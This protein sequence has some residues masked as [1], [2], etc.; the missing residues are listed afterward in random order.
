MEMTAPY[1]GIDVAKASLEVFGVPGPASLPN[2]PKAA[3]ALART[4]LKQK[5]TLIALEAT[6]GYERLV[7]HTLLEAGLP[8]VRLN[9]LRVRRFAQSIG[10]LAKTDAI[11]AKL[12]A[13]YA[14]V[15]ADSLSPMKATSET[16]KMLKELIARRRQLVQQCTASRAQL[17]HVTISSVKA[18]IDRTIKHLKKEI[19]AIETLI[20]KQIDADE[21]MKAKAAIL[22]S[23]PGIDPRVAAILIS[24]L[25]ELGEI[26]RRQIA[27]LVGVAPF[28][29]DS[30]THKG[31]RHIQGGRP[32]VR[33]ALYMATLVG[34]RRDG[35]LKA[36][37]DHLVNAGKPKKVAIVACMRTRL[38]YLTALVK[39]NKHHQPNA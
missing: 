8:A 11:D 23:V 7:L 32:T 34:I 6:G 29:D 39:H 4:L 14:R 38:N 1:I 24:E 20:Q 9:P 17:E 3:R 12:L 22:R 13:R 2:T 33:S 35:V 10:A 5:P 28:N 19:E 25:P 26:D 31:Q 36:R 21:A 37:Y 27:A 16:A 18:S 15:N 30:G